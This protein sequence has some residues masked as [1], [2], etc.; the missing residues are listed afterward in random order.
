MKIVLLINIDDILANL[1]QYLAPIVFGIIS[2]IIRINRVKIA[3]AIP[4]AASPKT[5][6]TCAPTPAAPTV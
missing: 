3:D 1:L 5:L 4:K 6:T 2:V